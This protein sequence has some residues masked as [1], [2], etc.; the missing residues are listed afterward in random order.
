MRDRYDSAWLLAQA[1]RL[2]SNNTT[3]TAISAPLK[4]LFQSFSSGNFSDVMSM[5][6]GTPSLVPDAASALKITVAQTAFAIEAIQYMSI[7]E[8]DQEALR[9]FRLGVKRRLLRSN[10]DLKSLEKALMQEAL[11]DLYK[12]EQLR[13]DS[14]RRSRE[15]VL[16]MKKEIVHC[17]ERGT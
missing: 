1:D 5:V 10:K 9:S 11:E 3:S 12:D 17:I 13:Y 14:V 7:P 4:S 2:S 16:L 15:N 8:D 6:T